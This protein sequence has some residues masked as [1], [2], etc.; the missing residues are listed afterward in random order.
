MVLPVTVVDQ[1]LPLAT[2][3]T[4]ERTSGATALR[5]PIWAEMAST[6]ASL[7]GGAPAVLSPGPRRWPG[8]TCSRLLPRLLIWSRTAWVAPL[9]TVTMVITAATPMTMPS[10]VRKE[11]SRLRRM[12]RRASRMELA[13]IRRLPPEAA[14]P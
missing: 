5:P 14:R 4:A 13:H 3:V 2:T 12:A 8:R 1:F 7:K 10:T 6:S 11:R 9:P